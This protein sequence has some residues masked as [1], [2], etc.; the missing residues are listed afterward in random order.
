MTPE[1]EV[2][3]AAHRIAEEAERH[4]AAE[5]HRMAREIGRTAAEEERRIVE[6]VVA[7]SRHKA[8]AEEV[9]AG[10]RLGG[11]DIDPAGVVDSRRRAAAEAEAA[12]SHPV[13]A[14]TGLQEGDTGREG[15]TA[16]RSLA[17]VADRMARRRSLRMT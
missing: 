16:G 10:N 2:P 6:E 11:V 17:E 5:E 12:D 9:A 15:G 3:R 13:G 8:A 7:D 4:T 14:D 1:S